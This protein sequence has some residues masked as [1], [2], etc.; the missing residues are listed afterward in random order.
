MKKNLNEAIEK[1]SYLEAVF[2]G[3]PGSGNFAHAGRKGLV[4][5][6]TKK[7]E[8]VS[9]PT[10]LKVVIA[11][12][13]MSSSEAKEYLENNK[14]LEVLDRINSKLGDLKELEKSVLLDK[15]WVPVEEDGKICGEF[16]DKIN[17]HK[18]ALGKDDE[19]VMN[20][21]KRY[22]ED[23]N[24][25]Y[26]V[27]KPSDIDGV[28]IYTTTDNES[29]LDYADGD[30]SRICK[31]IVDKSNFISQEKLN[32]I[33]KRLR[34]KA[35]NNKLKYALRKVEGKRPYCPVKDTILAG[36]Y[37]YDGIIRL[38][39][40][41]YIVINPERL[42]LDKTNLSKRANEL[43]LKINGLGCYNK[44]KEIK[45]MKLTREQYNFVKQKLEELEKEINGGKGSGNFGH[46]GR[47]GYV[48]GSGK[49]GLSSG[50]KDG[51]SSES[52]I[53]RKTA[54]DV[55]EAAASNRA[56][57]KE[58]SK[59]GMTAGETADGRK[60]IN[61]DSRV[62]VPGDM[63]PSDIKTVPKLAQNSEQAKIENEFAKNWEDEGRREE[64]LKKISEMEP[65]KSGTVETDAI[66]QLDPN[67]GD[68]GRLKEL[69][70][71]KEA[72]DISDS[73]NNELNGYLTYRQ[74]NNTLLHQTA[75]VLAKEMLKRKL[76][77]NPD[78]VL[79]VTSGGC[80]SGKG[81]FLEN[82]DAIG[83][84]VDRPW[85]KLKIED[86]TNGSAKKLI[87]SV[88]GNKNLVVWDA[89][90][91][92]NSSELNWLAN[93]GRNMTVV[94]TVGDAQANAANIKSGLVSRA[95]QKGR[96]VD[97]TV[98]AESYSK[99]NE[100]TSKFYRKNKNNSKIQFLKV[101]NLGAG[102]PVTV[103]PFTQRTKYDK[104]SYSPSDAK[105]TVKENL[106]N[107]KPSDKV[108]EETKNSIYKGA[109]F[110]ENMKKK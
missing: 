9:E 102:K 16:N 43:I 35:D 24:D 108:S 42:S 45:K 100:N 68:D 59:L 13:E 1:I 94:H 22:L 72:G 11:G 74:E 41:E 105:N 14:D 80:A 34:S 97:T 92:Q 37:G 104:S 18:F 66:K 91:D 86:M 58:A 85:G 47:P 12:K 107:L 5:G 17:R 93:F 52:E 65:F 8:S 39:A 89:A 70:K 46:S 78:A 110:I 55:E 3:G 28:A 106:S 49:G 31:L 90:G 20:N 84:E 40:N 21:G 6:S 54:K 64:A 69:Q 96:M 83:R 36:M 77:A 61:K 101:E 25:E 95:L 82:T 7:G 75:N 19:R 51:G 76:M 50:K 67:W 109:T 63:D 48:G 27:S 87:D 33:R 71:K 88:L 2:N 26:Y 81:F 103:M 44:N 32:E 23:N 38:D 29:A 73:E 4:G 98:Y 79:L 10:D 15:G 30:E 60:Y 56:V 99:G 53:M 57:E 62:G